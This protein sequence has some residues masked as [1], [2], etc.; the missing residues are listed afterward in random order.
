[1][2][3]SRSTQRP[4]PNAPATYVH[5]SRSGSQHDE[6]PR[7]RAGQDEA[8]GLGSLQEH[9][10]I[11]KKTKITR[12]RAHLFNTTVLPALTYISETWALRRQDENVVSVIERSIERM[13]LGLTQVR[14]GIRSSSLR[15]QSKIRDATVY[16][17]LSK[18][19]RVGRTRDAPKRPPLDE[20]RQRLDSGARKAHD[21]KTTDPMV[22]LLH[23]ALQR[24]T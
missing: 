13:M 24:T 14:A 18:M 23:E 6:R 7:S 20:S 17:K 12:L 10:D 11:V 9:R 5:I 15:Q 8:S 22:R 16:A 4:S 2:P 19:G 3:H 21:R 1:M